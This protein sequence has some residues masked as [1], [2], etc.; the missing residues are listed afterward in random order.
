MEQLRFFGQIAFVHVVAIRRPPEL[1]VAEFNRK[2]A[3]T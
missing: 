2:R 3:A 1:A